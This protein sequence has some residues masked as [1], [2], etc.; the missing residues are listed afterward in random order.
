MSPRPEPSGRAVHGQVDGLD[1]VGQH[2]RPTTQAETQ[3]GWEK[4]SRTGASPTHSYREL[5]H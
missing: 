3:V 4:G 5:A 2:D 1:T